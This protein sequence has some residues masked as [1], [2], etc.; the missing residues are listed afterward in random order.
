MDHTTNKYRE[1]RRLRIIVITSGI[2]FL[3]LAGVG[4]YGLLFAPAAS[5]QPGTSSPQAPPPQAETEDG[6]SNQ[7]RAPR[8]I[9]EHTDPDLFVRAVAEGVFGWDTGLGGSPGDYMQPLIDIADWEEAPGLAA[10]LRSYY[11]DDE[12]WS[13][14]RGYS[15]KQWILVD[16]VS[17]PET[18][19][20]IVAQALPGQLPPG[21]SAFTITGARHRAGVWEGEVITDTSP[22]SF[23][24][25]VACPTGEPC[26]L[27]RLSVVDTPMR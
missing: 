17:V 19:A 10:D 21:A 3:L 11:P 1:S 23:T 15:T 14:L 4:V 24:V 25:F 18:W 20:G 2:A 6:Q 12:T 9:T 7:D 27:L 22:T 26:R 8:L 13:A 5:S 16:S